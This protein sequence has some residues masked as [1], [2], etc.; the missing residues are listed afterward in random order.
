MARQ[1]GV[2]VA[3]IATR[4]IAHPEKAK[5]LKTANALVR[6]AVCWVEEGR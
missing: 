4:C 2:G 5:K 6:Y 1:L 3:T